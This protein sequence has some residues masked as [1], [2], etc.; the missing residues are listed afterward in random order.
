ML[1]WR[2]RALLLKRVRG[3]DLGRGYN[4]GNILHY[5]WFD[6]TMSSEGS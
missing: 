4:F 1:A 2:N 5:I 6:D 3:I